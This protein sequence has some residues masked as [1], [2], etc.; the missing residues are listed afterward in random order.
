MSFKKGESTSTQSTSFPDY[1]TDAQRGL[2]TAAGGLATPFIKPST[3]ALAGQNADQQKAAELAR[4]QAMG[5]F[6]TDYSA[7]ISRAGGGFRAAQL[8]NPAQMEAAQLDGPAQMEAY[9]VS[10]EDIRGEMNPFLE[11]VGKQTL[12]DMRREKMATDAQI[13]ARSASGVA[14]GGSGPAL[15]RAQ[16]DRA[17]GE[18]VGSTI[19]GLMAQ[20]YDRA[21]AI[22]L[23]KAG[24]RDAARQANVNAANQFSTLNFGAEN[25]ARMRNAD[26]A[27][28]F[29]TLN[30]GAENTARSSNAQTALAAQIAANSAANSTFERQQAALQQLLGIGNQNQQFAQ[31]GID[32]PWT[33]LNKAAAFLPGVGSTTTSSQPNYFN[34]LEA[35][36]GVGSLF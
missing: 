32:I 33:Q 34:P 7:P 9:E 2:I 28:Q 10:S 12:A 15:Q 20:G 18:Q 17:Y 23:Q 16:L 6:N 21:T 36:V 29:S 31:A 22:A 4:T 14:F 8:G 3:S 26:A 1:V 19:N 35:L 11:S 13:G 30:F 27:N 25:N 24:A 5:A